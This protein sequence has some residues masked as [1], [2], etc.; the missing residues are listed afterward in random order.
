MTILQRSTFVGTNHQDVRPGAYTKTATVEG[1]VKD[2]AYLYE[3]ITDLAVPNAGSAAV[4]GHDHTGNGDG[5]II[6][7]PICQQYMGALLE[8]TAAVPIS[9][10][11]NYTGWYKLIWHPFYCQPGVDTVSCILWVDRETYAYSENFRA[12]IQSPSFAIVGLAQTANGVREYL[13]SDN[14][15]IGMVYDLQATPGIVNILAV[16]AWDG[17]YDKTV[18]VNTNDVGELLP[19]F[20]RVVGF[21]LMPQIKKPNRSIRSYTT[22]SVTTGSTTTPGSFTSFDSAL[23]ADDV[24]LSSYHLVNMAKNDAMLQELATGNPAG[25]SA[26]SVVD[27]HNHQD[28]GTVGTSG[29]LLKRTIGSWFYGTVRTPLGGDQSNYATTLALTDKFPDSSLTS[30]WSG[31]VNA[32]TINNSAGT[33]EQVVALHIFRMPE[34]TAANLAESTG[35]INVSFFVNVNAAQ[36]DLTIKAEIGNANGTSFGNAASTTVSTTGRQIV[37][38]RAVDASVLGTGGVLGTLRITMKNDA[39]KAAASFLYGSCIWCEP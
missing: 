17:Y 37:T 36:A 15:V 28:G 27:G 12:Y 2:Q 6:R 7:V 34:T 23:V 9:G 30:K 21:T 31:G 35:A 25:N 11:T 1:I 8:R 16:D 13:T 24:G 5:A 4:S 18:P 22:P 3:R 20:R 33:T 39:S 29:A 26:S 10:S 38:L 19:E 14:D 32:I